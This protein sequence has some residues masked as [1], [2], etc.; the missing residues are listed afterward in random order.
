MHRTSGRTAYLVILRTLG[1]GFPV[2][3]PTATNAAN[4]APPCAGR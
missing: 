3:A 2:S 1:A 4:A